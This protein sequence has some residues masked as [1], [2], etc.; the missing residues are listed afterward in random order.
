MRYQWIGHSGQKSGGSRPDPIKGRFSGARREGKVSLRV[1]EN[2][3]RSTLFTRSGADPGDGDTTPPESAQA[4]LLRTTFGHLPFAV[5]GNFAASMTL[6]IGSWAS[7]SHAL[8]LCWLGI[9]ILFNT[10]RW[11]AARHVPQGPMSHEV[12]RRWDRAFL[13]SALLSGAL[14]G[15]AGG[16]LFI[17][18]DSGHNFFVALHVV[19]MAAAAATSLS[20][21]RSAF[22]VFCIAAVAPITLRLMMEDS[23]PEKAVGFVL[24]LYFL[25]ILLLSRSIYKAAYAAA[26]SRIEER[27]LAYHDHLTGVAN[28]RYFEEALNREWLRGRRS[29]RPISLVILDID[30][31]KRFNDTYGHAVGDEVL[32]AV[33]TMILGRLRR[34]GDLVARFGGEEFAV[35]LPET[36]C[37]GARVL[38]EDLC[39]RARHLSAPPDNAYPA[40]TLSAG[41]SAC[42]P[43]EEMETDT[44]LN[45]A[46]AA[47]Y[48]AKAG[49][50]D[51]VQVISLSVT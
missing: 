18:G 2:M 23:T 37:D 44:L 31:F 50:K 7:V 35:L 17:P 41:L 6:T 45:A 13:G 38:A 1:A 34:G 24:P 29:G 33:A 49:G 28:R 4:E 15:F 8:L 27:H 42:I 43:R 40:P 26:L 51:R 25:F 22:P 48:Q 11:L 47:L 21:H 20:Y 10:V 3:N 9:M 5:L 32:Q 36:D 39:D 46:D 12:L 16:T 19:S 14:W 30:N